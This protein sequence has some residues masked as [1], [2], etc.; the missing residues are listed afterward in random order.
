MHK[1]II[2]AIFLT[3]QT[4]VRASTLFMPDS[5][6]AALVMLV[7]N[8]ASTVTNTLKI[9]EVAKKTSNQI[10]KYNFLAMRKFFTARRIEQHVRDIAETKKMKPKGLKEINRVLARLKYNLKGLKSSIDSLGADIIKSDHFTDKIYE[11]ISNSF[12]DELEAFNQ[13][14]LSASEGEMS[15]H[16]QNT[17]MNTAISSKI[18]AKMRRD[19]LE[20]QR[21]DIDIKKNR[22][23]EALRRDEFYREWI[24]LPDN[25]EITPMGYLL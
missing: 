11:K 20:Y 18:L 25:S 24:G 10:D 12:N 22:S 14:Q 6:T 7:A 9:L 13:E 4:Q 21:V 16:V 23:V 8:T 3:L 5:D 17:A 1:N 2:L 19:Q 15:K